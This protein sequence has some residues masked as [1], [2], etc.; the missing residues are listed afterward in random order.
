MSRYSVLFEEDD[1]D[2]FC[3][4]F[5]EKITHLEP[6][7]NAISIKYK[8]ITHLEPH[9]T[10]Y[11]IKSICI[12]HGAYYKNKVRFNDYHHLDY[13]YLYRNPSQL[14]FARNNNDYY[15]DGILLPFELNNI[16]TKLDKMKEKLKV[17]KSIKYDI[18][19]RME[20]EIRELENSCNTQC[21][22]WL[23]QI[24]IC[25]C[26]KC[27]NCK[28]N[29]GIDVCDPGRC[30]HYYKIQNIEEDIEWNENI[31]YESESEYC[32]LKSKYER[33]LAKYEK[34]LDEYER[35]IEDEYESYAFHES[36][37]WSNYHRYY[38]PPVYI[39]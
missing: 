14:I 12:T 39:Y 27:Y 32:D 8:N 3:F 37:N 17:T 6:H 11:L 24:H 7:P 33:E 16:K 15:N 25:N 34:R 19:F 22:K 1:E 9:P 31:V 23:D 35:N 29:C 18:I 20:S 21:I 30:G 10:S 36:L 2:N 5:P 4:T 26:E 38:K 13:K 28:N